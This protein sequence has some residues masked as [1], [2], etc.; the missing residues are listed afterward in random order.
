MGLVKGWSD[1][2]MPTL[3]WNQLNSS[4]PEGM[5]FSLFSKHRSWLQHSAV[6]GNVAGAE[7]GR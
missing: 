3:M 6:H 5:S 4:T 2:K 7:M 1:A